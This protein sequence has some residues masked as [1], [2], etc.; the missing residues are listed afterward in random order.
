MTIWENSAFILACVCA[1]CAVSY[2]RRILRLASTNN[3]VST[4]FQHLSV[5]DPELEAYERAC[6]WQTRHPMLTNTA[7]LT[8]RDMAF[9]LLAPQHV[10]RPDN[11][12][13]RGS[14]GD[15]ADLLARRH[16]QHSWPLFAPVGETNTGFRTSC[17]SLKCSLAAA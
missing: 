7:A 4:R 12:R 10:S 5:S 13:Q 3:E 1:T 9:R 17:F 15:D 16:S 6:S 11:G 2:C 8:G 14:R